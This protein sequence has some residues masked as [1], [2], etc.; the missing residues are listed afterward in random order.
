MA[1][2]VTSNEYDTIRLSWELPDY[3]GGSPLVSYRV[4]IQDHQGSFVEDLANCDG[5]DSD[6]RANLFC[7]IPMPVLRSEPYSLTLGD[8][9]VA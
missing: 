5:T 8:T 2:V 7:I 9:V 3:D 4:K 1:A 6:I